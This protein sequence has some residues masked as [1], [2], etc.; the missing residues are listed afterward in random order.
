MTIMTTAYGEQLRHFDVEDG[1]ESAGDLTVYGK[2]TS[3]LRQFQQACG[4][5]EQSPQPSHLQ[6][7]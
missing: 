6:S 1:L 7:Q 4:R 2:Q 3:R 5:V